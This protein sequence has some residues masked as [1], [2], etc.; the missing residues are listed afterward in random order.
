MQIRYRYT[1]SDNNNR[2]SFGSLTTNEV[3]MYLQHK[4]DTVIITTD[5][6]DK[7]GQYKWVF[8]A[9]T[10]KLYDI[11]TGNL[12]ELDKLP[13]LAKFKKIRYLWKLLD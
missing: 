4:G 11:K 13:R 9:T 1:V 6:Q 7:R 3:T 8:D 10:T 5:E 12:D 2:G